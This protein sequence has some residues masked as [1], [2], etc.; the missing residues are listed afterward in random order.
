MSSSH[1]HGHDKH[2]HQGKQPIG[3]VKQRSV[4]ATVLA[5]SLVAFVALAVLTVIAYM[6]WG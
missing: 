1:K 4:L 5:F 6:I 3:M 2:S